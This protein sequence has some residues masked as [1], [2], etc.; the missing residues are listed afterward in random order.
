MEGWMEWREMRELEVR[1]GPFQKLK[2]MVEKFERMGN[3][4]W[5]FLVVVLDSMTPAHHFPTTKTKK[6]E[7]KKEKRKKR[8][9]RIKNENLPN[10]GRNTKHTK[11]SSLSKSDCSWWFLVSQFQCQF[12]CL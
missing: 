8:I 3:A 4:F 5:S 1:A 9:K 11:I 2:K 6:K 10:L 12:W 7:K